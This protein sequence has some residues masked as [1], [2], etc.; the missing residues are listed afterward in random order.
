MSKKKKKFKKKITQ[1]LSERIAQIKA[2]VSANL[3]VDKK[4]P[5]NGKSTET[6]ILVAETSDKYAYVKKD[7][8]RDLLII[9]ALVLLLAGIT[10][11][12]SK[13]VFL[14]DFAEWIYKILNLK[15]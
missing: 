7:I 9:L 6:T 15:V 1:N 13:T 12:N 5:D 11:L 2:E 10:I 4:V 14:K 3:P 8:R